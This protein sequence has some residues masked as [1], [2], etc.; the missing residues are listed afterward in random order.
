[1]CALVG[2][3]STQVRNNISTWYGQ[4]FTLHCFFHRVLVCLS[5]LHPLDSRSDLLERTNH[6]GRVVLLVR[7]GRGPG[8]VEGQWRRR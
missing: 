2:G 6:Q 3:A 1:M 4:E 7:G 5:L 8:R